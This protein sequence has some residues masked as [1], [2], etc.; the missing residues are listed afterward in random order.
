[1]LFSVPAGSWEYKVALND[2]WDE[3][4]GAYAVLGGA[5]IGLS[6]ADPTDVKF[7]Y[8]HKSHWVT[9]NYNSVIAT[10]AGSFQS[11][12][13]CPGDWQPD[14]LLSWLQD[15]DGDGTHTFSTTA[16]PMGSYAFKVTINESW[17]ENYGEGG[18]A[19]GADIPFNVPV[20]GAT[21]TFA[22][23]QT[24]KVPTV[25]VISGGLEP[26][27]ADLVRAPVRQ[28]GAG[29]VIYFVMTD[30]FANGDPSNDTAGSVSLDREVHGYDPTDKGFYHGGDLAGLSAQ[31]D[32]LQGLG[33]TALW[34]TPPFENRW[35]QGAGTTDVS[36]GYHGYWQVDLTTIDP[37]LGS[38]AEMQ[39][40]VAA[41]HARG[42][43]VYFDMVAN[44]TGDVIQ[45]VGGG[46]AYRSKADYPYR[47]ATGI[48]FDDR[49]YAG[50]A[51]FPPLDPAVSFPYE[52]IFSSHGRCQCESPGFPE[53]SN[54]VS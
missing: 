22:W 13:G 5:N 51:T 36:A 19:G 12:L 42:M 45:Y 49:D 40:L 27:D 1:M 30:R 44:H 8:D 10:A 39:A 21:I 3:N 43:K 14:C 26:G 4:Y 50:T 29:E 28:A 24:T 32:Y 54:A 6:L 7:Y 16:I 9:D 23:D 34:I 52:P 25:S 41:A 31:L 46:S 48:P 17:D 2:S 38:N 53:R 11:E 18:V 20:D 35:V 33:V 37:H 47:D 15:P